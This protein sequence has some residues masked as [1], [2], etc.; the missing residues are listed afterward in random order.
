MYKRDEPLKIRNI[1][2]GISID[3]IDAGKAPQVLRILGIDENFKD[4]VTLAMNVFSHKMK[5]KDIVK[6]EN[7]DLDVEEI[8]KIAIVAPN[9]TINWIKDFKVVRKEKVK[10]PKEIVSIIKCPNPSCVSNKEREPITSV[11][12]VKRNKNVRLVCKYCEREIG[13]DEIK[14]LL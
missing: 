4:S 2:N 8:N 9:A 7:R 6:V 13:I 1:K 3:H 11:F 10:L 14:D 12:Y 5:K